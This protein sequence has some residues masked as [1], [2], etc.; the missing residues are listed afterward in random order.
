[1]FG[2]LAYSPA[3]G[4]ILSAGTHTLSVTFTPDD[5]L[6]FVSSTKSVPIIVSKATPVIAW[7][8]PATIISGTPLGATQLNAGATVQGTTVPGTFAYTPGFGTILAPGTHTLSVTFT[9]TATNNYNSATAS[10]PITVKETPIVSWAPPANITYGT[11]LSATQLNASATVDGINVQGTFAYT[12][13]A[14]AIL[15]AGTHT[16]SVTFTPTD[17]GGYV[18]S[19]ASVPIT[20]VKASPVLTWAPPAN[21]VY[22]TPLG[23]TQ[24]NAGATVPGT[25]VYAPVSGTILN[26]GIHTLSVTFTPTDTTNYNNA[27]ASVPLT[28]VKATPVITWATP[29]NIVAGTPLGATQLNA[30][31]A[32][33]PGTLV[34]SPETG[35]V[36]PVGAAQRLTVTFTPA[37]TANYNT[38]TETVPITVTSCGLTPPV[39]APVKIGNQ[40]AGTFSDATGHSGQSHLVYAP[41]ASV[42]WLFTL[43]SAND[44]ARQPQGPDLRQQRA[45]PCDRHMD[46]RRPSAPRSANRERRHEFAVGGRPIARRGGSKHRRRRLRARVHL[47]CLRRPD[48]VER[49]HPRAT[50]S[51]NDHLGRVEQPRLAQHRIG[52]AGPA[53][54]RQSAAPPTTTLLGQLDR[55]FLRRLHPSLQRRDGPGSGL[56]RRPF[57]QPGHRRRRG[58]T[59]SAAT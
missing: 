50:R 9:P 10:V 29:A 27:V 2:S 57:D 59:A 37:D 33:P 4:T 51:D 38:V 18:L 16:L 26:A 34:Y 22:G 6:H 24:L 47:V 49:P 55:H 28:V 8:P 42:W 36:L 20:V 23:A 44:C 39:T 11:P 40:I 43:S 25:R 13:A 1:M 45:G 31:V 30:T 14:G 54:H 58:P 53:G 52:V 32:S 3:A 5:T 41:N 21:I 7:T 15:T 46:G 48:V 12:P 17:Q 56:Q 19:S 35:T